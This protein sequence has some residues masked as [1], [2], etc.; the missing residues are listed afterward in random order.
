VRTVFATE[1]GEQH[2]PLRLNEFGSVE[3]TSNAKSEANDSPISSVA[4]VRQSSEAVAFA[5]VTR[6]SLL[7]TST[8]QKSAS[9]RRVREDS[10]E[11]VDEEAG[12]LTRVARKPALNAFGE[13]IDEC[14][15]IVGA[16]EFAGSTARRLR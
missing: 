11:R 12:S 8:A 14:R 16:G 6:P 4:P 2:L 10:E 7:K 1:A 9:R 5:E 13:K 3:T 15:V